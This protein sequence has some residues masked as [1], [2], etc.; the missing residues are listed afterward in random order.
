MSSTNKRKQQIGDYVMITI[1]TM[2]L[3][4]AVN[5]ILD[6]AG[7][8][9][10]GFSGLGIAIRH[11]TKD[12]VS[13]GIPIWFTNLILNL[14]LLAV[15]IRIR[16][17]DFLKKTI[18]GTLMSSFWFG[19]LPVFGLVSDDRMLSALFGG[20]IMGTGLGLVFRANGTTG[21]TDLLAAL[22]QRFW[23]HYSIAQIMQVLDGLIVFFGVFVF[24]IH[25]ALYA[26]V[27][28]FVSAKVTDTLIEGMNYAKSVFII[29]EK[30]EVISAQLMHELDRG[31]TGIHIR[32]MYT[33]TER[34]MIFCVTGKKQIPKLKSVI[35]EI[36]PSAFV[37]VTDAREVLGEG[38]QTDFS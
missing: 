24:G 7:L 38:F 27:A 9:T 16:G 36:D 12:L 14:P 5:S 34:M 19:V 3:A 4:L 35:A 37:V 10:G 8:V 2:L 6:P 29:T 26:I 22:V 1:G 21:G 28:I 15:S 25:A 23:R 11:L 32:G 18:F 13:G 31:T 20:V 30:P 33:K 17:F